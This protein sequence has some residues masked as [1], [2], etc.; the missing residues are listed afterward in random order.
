MLIGGMWLER[1]ESRHIFEVWKWLG[2]GMLCD[3]ADFR[4]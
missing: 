2:F 4:G 1:L 3:E